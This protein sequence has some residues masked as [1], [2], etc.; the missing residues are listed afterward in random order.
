MN[1]QWFPFG[2]RLEAL[3]PELEDVHNMIPYVMRQVAA[4]V[5]SSTPYS[6][7]SEDRLCLPSLL[8]YWT[9]I[10]ESIA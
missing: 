2:H 6:Y 8:V 4:S 9:W 10:L 7:L 5:F 3:N 1:S